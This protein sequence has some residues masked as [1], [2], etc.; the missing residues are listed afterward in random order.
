[1]EGNRLSRETIELA[2]QVIRAATF[3]VTGAQLAEQAD[4]IGKAISVLEAALT[5]SS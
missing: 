1:V 3:N 5:E 2:L 4:R